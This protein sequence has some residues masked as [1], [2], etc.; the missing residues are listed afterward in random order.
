MKPLEMKD[1]AFLRLAKE[2]DN[3]SIGAGSLEGVFQKKE[4]AA[5]DKTVGEDERKAS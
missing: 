4:S 3:C 5:A 1:D 2:E